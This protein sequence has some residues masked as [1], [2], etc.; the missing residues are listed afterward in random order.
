MNTLHSHNYIYIN[1]LVKNMLSN[2]TYKQLPSDVIV[3]VME[4]ITVYLSSKNLN[5]NK[6]TKL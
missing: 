4:P 1:K 5:I 3:L 2:V 6:H